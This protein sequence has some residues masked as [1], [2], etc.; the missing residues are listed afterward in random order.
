MN[1]INK[2]LLAQ[3]IANFKNFPDGAKLENDT[4]IVEGW[5]KSLTHDNLEKTKEKSMQQSFLI[6]FFSDILGFEEPG[7]KSDVWN[8]YPEYT[9][10][11]SSVSETLFADGA[12][13]YFSKDRN[14]VKAVIE[15]KDALTP[16]DKKQSGREKGYTPVGQAFQYAQKIDGCNWIIVSNFKEIRL[17]NKLR[18][19]EL[20]EAISVLELANPENFKRFYYLLCRENLISE[21]PKSVMDSVL[22]QSVEN[23][24]DI[25]KKF[26][27]E[28]KVVRVKFFEHLQKHNPNLDK[29]TL[30]EKTQKLLDRFIFVLFCE[31][32]N[33]LLPLNISKQTYQLGKKSRERS[34]EKIWRE[35]R[36]LFMDIDEGRLDVDPQINKYNG[37]LFRKDDV[38]DAMSIK[39]EIWEELMRLTR[40]DFDSDLN[41][42]ILGHIFEQSIS[43]LETLRAEISGEKVV[44]SKSKRKKEGVYYTPEYI[45]KYIVENTVGRWMEENP[46][47]LENVTILDPACGS[48]AFLN[49]A[50]LFLMKQ[51]RLRNEEAMQNS[52]GKMRLFNYHVA[53]TTIL[54]KNLHGVDLNEESV[55]ITK[56][57]LWLKTATK[58]E[59]LQNLDSNIKCG[60]SLIDDPEVAGQKAFKW[61]AEFKYVMDAG[62][63]DVVVSNPPYLKELDN[64]DVFEPIKRSG[65]SK[66][67]QGKMDLWYLF[68]HRAIDLCK[69]NGYIGFITNSYFLK[70]AGASKLVERI[71]SELT[72]V[73]F[74][75]FD[76]Y[77]VFP[78]VSG[79]HIIHVYQKRKAK[80]D[81]KTT[82]NNINA[83]SF[84]GDMLSCNHEMK[85]TKELFS[86]GKMSID[87]YQDIFKNRENEYLDNL[88][89]VSQGV[90][91]GP[92]RITTKNA[93][94]FN[95]ILDT[96]VF[97]L[98]EEEIINHHFNDVENNVIKNYLDSKD[99]KKYHLSICQRKSLL[100]CSKETV[101]DINKL[102]NILSHLNKFKDVISQRRETL[103]GKLPFYYLHW[104]R[105]QRFFENP[106]LICKGM[107]KKP[108]FYYDEDKYYVGFSFSVIISRD[109]SYSLK[110]L[111][112]CL[113][114]RV[115]EYW[116]NMNAKRRGIGVDVGVA[117][118]RQFPI[119]KVDNQSKARIEKMVDEIQ[120]KS[121]DYFDFRKI[122]NDFFSEEYSI[123]SE[124]DHGTSWKNLV[125]QM[126]KF[127][128]HLN[129]EKKED[130][131]KWFLAKIEKMKM[132]DESI[133]VLDKQI[134]QEVYKLY[135]LT[136]DEI[137]IIEE[138]VI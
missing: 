87:Q 62:G 61:E 41:V 37:G 63:F 68:L 108:E 19:D 5:I 83:V 7:T 18:S 84:T 75:D 128:I 42:N 82:I 12:L 119:P 106:K 110:V 6:R 101:D 115:G 58:S 76:D 31:D 105:E 33:G 38:L 26:Y 9:I 34:D 35:F 39:D 99:L 3:K 47:K 85:Q 28:Y 94:K 92:D 23:D 111:L 10:E 52:K 13:G 57:S 80:D 55:E 134:D 124:I 24:E 72:P 46:D 103:V 36:N 40:W 22:L 117:V 65:Y 50:H 132:M 60:N 67:Y 29:H 96:G 136:S 66:H 25:T 107:F 112:A 93:V 98:S 138:G 56:L 43:D 126:E 88:F 91:E 70:N 17:Y 21:G 1:L 90:V 100:Y 15:L 59:P 114:S 49:Q 53:E 102:P 74:F 14:V 54:S 64:S 109:D 130:L 86:N 125:E 77:P 16:L 104:P 131:Y 135:N 44:K 51:F 69:E 71:R 97:I 78:E 122:T 129:N 11:K 27:A 95:M 81:D 8:L 113:N 123:K 45:T 79:K 2:K 118:F 121:K 30:L 116:F 4:K 137:K 89:E 20:F 127:K 73:L 32:T 48:G 133:K 120:Q